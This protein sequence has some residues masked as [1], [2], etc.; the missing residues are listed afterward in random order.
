MRSVVVIGGGPAAI[1]FSR[2]LKKLK[3]EAEITMFRPEAHSMVYCAIPYAIEGLFEPSKVFK[4]DELVTEVGVDLIR[5]KVVS[6]DFKDKHVVDDAGC[7]GIESQDRGRQEE[8]A[9][10]R[11][12]GPQ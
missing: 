4:P 7:G 10:H 9:R 6:V 3:P 2:T 1:T 5:R 11:R 8:H 12:P